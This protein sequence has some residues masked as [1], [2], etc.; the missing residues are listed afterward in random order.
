MSLRRHGPV[1]GLPVILVLAVSLGLSLQSDQ[2]DYDVRQH[3]TKHEYQIPM[4]DGIKLFT[5][6]YTPKDNSRTYPFLM[7]RTPYS[8]G[9]YGV[10]NY[11]KVLGPHEGFVEDRFIFVYQDV[12]G[13]YMSE[14]EF[15]HMR[16][17]LP[18]KNGPKE[19]D[20]ST[21]TYDT[22]EWL[23]KNVPH[24]NGR[25][26]IYG[27]SYPGFY[28]AAGIIDSHPAIKAA[29]PQAPIGD[30]FVGDDFHHHGAFFLQDAFDFFWYAGRPRP[31]PT[32]DSPGKFPYKTADAYQFFL[33]VGP[34][35]EL[36]QKH[37]KGEIV[38]W[39]DLAAHGTYDEFWQKRNIIP[40]MKNVRAA[41]MTVAGLFDAEDP[42]GPIRIYQSIERQNKAIPNTMVLGPWIHGGWV[43]TLGKTLGNVD[44]HLE[45]GK[46][47]EEEID[48]PFF[49]FYLK[50]EGKMT[51]PEARVFITGANLWQSFQSWP[52][53]AARERSLYL[54]AQGGL[55]F[56]PPRES[57]GADS[58][59]SDPAKPV[60]YTQEIRIDR[61]VEYMVEDQRFAAR[62]PD[63][64]VYQTPEL[65]EDLTVT[66]PLVADLFV[67]STGTDADFVVKLIDVF[68]DNYM[69]GD[70]ESQGGS[71]ATPYM[72][73]PMGGYQMLVRGDIMRAKF[74][75]SYETPEPLVPNQVTEVRFQMPDVAHTFKTGH[76]I[77]IQVQSSWFPLVD[78]NP[79]TFVDIYNA[80]ETDFRVATQKIHRSP[81][82]P[83][84]VILRVLE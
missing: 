70:G 49:K 5:A 6:V 74:R 20:E 13:R 42:Y 64:L 81:E 38:F 28:T 18:V 44:F 36:D 51:L 65:T 63:V 50:D 73:V 17:H 84:R 62:R 4:R 56:D 40:H 72:K 14:G 2:R 83:S 45:T 59:V 69:S 34:L 22:V 52:P 37:F 55:A 32:T 21:D 3:Y 1:L 76:R 58:Y 23:L 57:E 25:L 10:D 24:N 47:Y 53:E 12:R 46:Q 75:K 77:M 9:P 15:V 67:S 68:P 19:I 82:S 60:P 8:V 29:S 35:S 43:R 11:K 39:H 79:Q 78:R 61:S 71:G 41:V 27:I 26:G 16:P 66:G 31:A 33:D 7:E 54:A 48:L 30:W 80:K